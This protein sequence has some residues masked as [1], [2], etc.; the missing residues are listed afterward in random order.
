MRRNISAWIFGSSGEDVAA[1]Q[2]TMTSGEV[3]D[4]PNGFLQD[5]LKYTGHF[6]LDA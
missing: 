5:Q 6:D 4:Q 3:G 2:I 1:F